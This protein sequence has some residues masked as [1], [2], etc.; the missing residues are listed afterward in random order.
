MAII[1]KSTAYAGESDLQLVRKD[2]DTV[3][4]EFNKGIDPTTIPQGKIT[5]DKF[6]IRGVP[7]FAGY[8]GTVANNSWGN[9]LLGINTA[10]GSTSGRLSELISSFYIDWYVSPSGVSPT[11]STLATDLTAIDSKGWP[12]SNGRQGT[13]GVSFFGLGAGAALNPK[14]QIVPYAGLSASYPTATS[15][16]SGIAEINLA[17]Y[18]LTGSSQEIFY[19]VSFAV[20]AQG[21]FA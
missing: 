7:N 13:A 12:Y 10:T 17:L 20:I 16:T 5:A 2:L 19:I 4:D 8:L 15:T 14:D 1:N 18:N 6:R 3:I 11:S 21:T 9:L